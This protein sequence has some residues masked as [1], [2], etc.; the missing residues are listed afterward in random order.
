MRKKN[1][2]EEMTFPPVELDPAV[3]AD[4]NTAAAAAAAALARIIRGS[5]SAVFKMIPP[6]STIAFSIFS[7]DSSA[8]PL[9]A[10][11]MTNVFNP[12]DRASR[13]LDPTQ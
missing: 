5:T 13:A 7:M 6:L 11:K 1:A 4:A 9:E 8:I 10:S 12:K 3:A 2:E